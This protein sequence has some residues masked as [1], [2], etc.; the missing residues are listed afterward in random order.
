MIIS[1]FADEAGVTKEDQAAALLR[2]GLAYIDVRA[3]DRKNIA[4]MTFS[5][6]EKYAAYFCGKGISVNCIG[7]PIGKSDIA[8]PPE[9]TEKIFS[10]ILCKAE[11]FGTDKVRIFSFYNSR[12]DFSA[13]AYRLNRFVEMAARKKIELYH[14][15]ELGIYGER[16]DDVFRLFQAVPGLEFI[17]D[18]ANFVLVGQN[19]EEAERIV[20]P[21]SNFFHIKDATYA[22]AI[23]P[24]GEGDGRI[25]EALGKHRPERVTIEPHLTEFD[26]Y[27][28][29]DGRKIRSKYKFKD[30]AS[31]FDYGVSAFKKL[32]GVLK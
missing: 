13:V 23:V 21:H 6:C 32:I 15:N 18:P 29:I 2:N 22:G 17:Y 8:E 1:A 19:I 31:A 30:E 4:D 28:N 3:I 16:A 24:A 7:S 12:K 25:S 14:E 10:D 9:A 11:L 27:A 26:G 5:E 20:L